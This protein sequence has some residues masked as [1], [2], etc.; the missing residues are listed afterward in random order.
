MT[1]NFCKTLK[2]VYMYVDFENI[3]V[4]LTNSKSHD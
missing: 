2:G 1:T 3:F 4:S